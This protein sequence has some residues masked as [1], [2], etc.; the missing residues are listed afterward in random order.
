MDTRISA[1]R[2]STATA[3]T[4]GAN[5]AQAPAAT[6]APAQSQ[7]TAGDVVDLSEIASSLSSDA[8]RL[9]NSFS[10]EDKERLAELVDNGA[11]SGQELNDGLIAAVKTSRK[12]QLW[13]IVFEKITSDPAAVRAAEKER[14]AF[15]AAEKELEAINEE[16]RRIFLEIS[17]RLG[18]PGT[19]AESQA[20]RDLLEKLSARSQ[21]LGRA[22]LMDNTKPMTFVGASGTFF[23]A[24]WATGI[25]TAAFEKL[26]SLGVVS[27]N[28]N[29]VID[30]DAKKTAK[31]NLIVRSINQELH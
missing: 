14:E 7:T 5:Q 24:N 6:A 12:R 4:K 9:F 15:N 31:E 20:Q 19:E 21:E 28:M 17:S 16:R 3:V 27:L 23:S 25:E 1:D 13:N 26:S 22:L 2:M 8:L 30:E 29:Q 11:I 18:K 10:N